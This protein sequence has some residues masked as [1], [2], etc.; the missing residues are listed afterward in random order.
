MSL[1]KGNTTVYALIGVLA[2][3]VIVFSLSLVPIFPVTYES[4]VSPSGALSAVAEEAVPLPPPP[5]PASHV[6]TPDAVK[7]IYMTSFV[8]GDVAWREKLVALIEETE[9][10]SIVIDIKDYTGLVAFPI[11]DPDFEALGSVEVR[12]PDIRDFI[13]SLH[14]KGI[15][16]IGR[17]AAF[18]DPA[19]V[20]KRP[21][22][23]VKKATDTGVV[24]ED[25]KGQTWVD[26]GSH[27]AWK[28][29]AAI[30]RG[31]Y[32]LG[33]DELNYDYIRFPS[34]GDMGDIHFPSSEGKVKADVIRDFSAYIH[35]VLNPLGAV[36]SVDLFGMT[37]TNR[38]DL[39]IGQILENELPY[40]DYIAPMV[41]PSH[42]PKNFLGYQNPAEKPYEVV[43]YSMD[44][45]VARAS[46]TPLKMRPWLQD[47]TLGAT[48]D[49]AKVRA[50]IQAVY[51]SGLMS[52]M[53]W[54]ASNRYTRGALLEEEG[55][56]T[57][58]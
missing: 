14:R 29:L 53:L 10:N 21:D 49:A 3:V 24:W 25:R 22:I 42:Y 26:P 2:I 5:L 52:W 7:A 18:Q 45:A 8:A 38:D 13:E 34:D 48:Y 47:F 43:K 19:L 31:A 39:N 23:A 44:K 41:Y 51:D 17:I 27:E 33:F 11:Q 57:V 56:D 54:N 46:T 58:Q 12:I 36:L 20:A 9:L 37:T 6:E 55:V 15:Y 4:G 28:Y 32:Y 1:V 30:G 35:G 50:Q 40:F 16:V